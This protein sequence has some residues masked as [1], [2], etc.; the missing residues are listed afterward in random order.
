MIKVLF[1]VETTYL[2]LTSGEGEKHLIDMYYHEQDITSD[3]YEVLTFEVS[4]KEA[5]IASS[6]SIYSIIELL[7]NM[8]FDVYINAE[9]NEDHI[10]IDVYYGETSLELIVYGQSIHKILFL[11]YLLARDHISAQKENGNVQTNDFSQSMH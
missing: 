7:N 2:Y 9:Y 5:E 3:R 11:A 4:Q 8:K 1:L 6:Q 10:L